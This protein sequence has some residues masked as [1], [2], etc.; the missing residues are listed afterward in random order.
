MCAPLGEHLQGLPGCPPTFLLPLL[1]Q[2]LP[3]SPLP[4]C[5]CC[6]AS[7]V[8]VSLSTCRALRASRATAMCEHALPLPTQSDTSKSD[9]STSD[10][11]TAATAIRYLERGRPLPRPLPVAPCLLRKGLLPILQEEEERG[12]LPLSACPRRRRRRRRRRARCQAEFLPVPTEAPLW[13][14][15]RLRPRAHSAQERRHGC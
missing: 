15:H 14:R 10:A 6:C 2:L 4:L 3:I 11:D 13:L 5:C 8:Q 7:T 1:V 9:T 12:S